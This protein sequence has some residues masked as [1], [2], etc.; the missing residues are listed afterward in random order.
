[1]RVLIAT[2]NKG[3]FG[4]IHG[5]LRDLPDA[6]FVFLGDLVEELGASGVTFDDSDFEEDGETHRENAY[7]KAD[8]YRRKV[9]EGFDYVLGEDSG[10][11]IDALADELGIETRRWGAGHD[12]SDEE[13]LEHFMGV[14][15]ERAAEDF[16]RG[17]KFVC[18]A[19]LVEG[20]GNEGE[21]EEYFEGETAGSITRNVASEVL[22]G[23]PLSS[24]F[25]ADG[26]GKVYAV[27]SQEE[28]NE[29][30][31]RGQAVSKL[32]GWFGRK[33]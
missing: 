10:I 25:L 31:H 1:M 3:K 9:G 32:K 7:K 23:L 6:E 28:K 12:A 5:V 24:V 15:E 8:Y 11:Y 29:I 2:K 18:S 4:E 21:V 16:E 20:G 33:I 27:L 19:C 22:P 14:M 26:F 30:S 17:A 13:W